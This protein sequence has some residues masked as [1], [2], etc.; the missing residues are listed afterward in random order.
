M[1]KFSKSSTILTPSVCKNPT[2]PHSFCFQSEENGQVDG[3]HA[4]KCLSGL[5]W[6]HGSKQPSLQVLLTVCYLQGWMP[7]ELHQLGDGHP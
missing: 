6:T 5:S 4:D 3:P 7:K 1:N 2:P